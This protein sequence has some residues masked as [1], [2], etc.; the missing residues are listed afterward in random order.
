TTSGRSL[1]SDRPQARP[2]GPARWQAPRAHVEL[3]HV[4][5]ARSFEKSSGAR[6]RPL[7]SLRDPPRP[8]PPQTSPA[9]YSNARPAEVRRNP[10]WGLLFH[11]ARLRASLFGRYR[12]GFG[13][14][15]EQRRQIFLCDR[16]TVRLN[17][18]HGFGEFDHLAIGEGL[19][20]HRNLI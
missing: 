10:G 18:P 15:V 16:R 3:L 19:H 20:E 7:S 8:A 1:P 6:L 14:P 5:T 12:T 4:G 2:V 9:L 13:P 11:C 17:L